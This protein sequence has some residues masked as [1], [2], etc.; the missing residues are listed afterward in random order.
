MADVT[1][2]GKPGCKGNAKQIRALRASGHS[3]VIHDLL[4][5]PWTADRLRAFFGA[6]PPGDWFNRSAEKV[7]S[8]AVDPDAFG[9]DDA[10]ATLI[11][12]P[13]LI[14]RPLMDV[15]GVRRAGWET[16]AVD[17]W[18]GLAPEAEQAGEGCAATHP[19]EKCAPSAA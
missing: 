16:E 4:T 15:A 10:L 8:G 9:E 19:D 6:T 17:L 12:D 2:F 5:E 18:I 7:K 14:R 11:A 13:M 1:F 3:V